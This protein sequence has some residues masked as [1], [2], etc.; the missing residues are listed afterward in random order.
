V[1][2]VIYTQGVLGTDGCP[3]G[4]EPIR[5]PSECKTAVDVGDFP[6]YIVTEPLLVFLSSSKNEDIFLKI[7]M[8]FI[9][10]LTRVLCL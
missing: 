6:A 10:I 2:L 9:F 7:A 1:P 4:F 3:T 5:T 8:M